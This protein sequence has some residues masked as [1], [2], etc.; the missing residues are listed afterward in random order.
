LRPK[1]EPILL[2]TILNSK[3]VRRQLV[4]QCRG[5]ASLD[6]R[7]HTLSNVLVPKSLLQS[8]NAAHICDLAA[9]ISMLRHQLENTIAQLSHYIETEFGGDAP[10]RPIAAK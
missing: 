3:G 10:I 8:D 1:I 7:E 9:E 5:A 6:I 4:A 2:V